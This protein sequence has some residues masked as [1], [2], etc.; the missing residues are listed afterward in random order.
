ME[1]TLAEAFDASTRRQADAERER[2]GHDDEIRARRKSDTIEGTMRAVFDLLNPPAGGAITD[3]D[4]P[5]SETAQRTERADIRTSPQSTRSSQAQP[6]SIGPR[7]F[8][9][10]PNQRIDE[11]D[12]ERAYRSLDYDDTVRGDLG[13]A[14][15]NPIAWARAWGMSQEAR[16]ATE[17]LFGANRPGEMS[18]AFRHAY[19]SYRLTEELGPAAAKRF[20]DGHESAPRSQYSGRSGRDDDEARLMDLYNNRVGRDLQRKNS[21]LGRKAEDVVLEAIANGELQLRPFPI[22]R[23]NVLRPPGSIFRSR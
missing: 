5:R 18:D 4:L 23:R 10:R 15:P 2:S 3:R 21:G 16:N 17:R 11:I 19:W 22:Y 7:Q 9:L 1:A 14:F 12:L 6:Q 13:N 20:T 8:H